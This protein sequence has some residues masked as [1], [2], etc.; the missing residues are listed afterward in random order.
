[1]K[2][3]ICDPE[4]RTVNTDAECGGPNDFFQ[5]S[6]VRAV[7]SPGSLVLR[8]HHPDLLL[9]CDSGAPPGTRL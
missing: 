2:P 8:G 7:R 1:M 9:P 4:Q 3:T 5:F 6:P